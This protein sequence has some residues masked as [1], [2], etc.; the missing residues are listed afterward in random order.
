MNLDSK[1]RLLEPVPAAVPEPEVALLARDPSSAMPVIF[2]L[3][4]PGASAAV[5]RRLQN[6]PPTEAIKILEVGEVGGSPCVVS[7]VLPGNQTLRDWMD[8]LGVPPAS[9]SVISP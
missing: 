6:L 4:A 8:S 3:L 1:Y 9:E 5:L 2:H 7:H